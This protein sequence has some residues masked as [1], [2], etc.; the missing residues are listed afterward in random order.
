MSYDK[1]NRL[2]V[3]LNGEV[4]TTYSYSGDGKKR[5]EAVGNALTTLVWDGEDYLQG[6]V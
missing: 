6:R 5:T 1:E 3:H 4:T 2:N